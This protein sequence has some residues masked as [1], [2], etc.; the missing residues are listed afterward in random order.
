MINNIYLY[1]QGDKIITTL[2]KTGVVLEDQT[3][4]LDDT[5]FTTT[6]DLLAAIKKSP[7]AKLELGGVKTRINKSLFT[8]KHE[9]IYLINKLFL[10]NVVYDNGTEE[11][12][13]QIYLPPN[14]VIY[15]NSNN[16]AQRIVP[17]IL[18]QVGDRKR[19]FI[20]QVT[21]V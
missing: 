3:A 7:L 20:K 15:D 5:T 1:K 6:E 12:S 9:S 2:G 14:F 8:L 17:F 11:Q 16:V 19:I 21:V 18:A 10:V 13:L 4:T